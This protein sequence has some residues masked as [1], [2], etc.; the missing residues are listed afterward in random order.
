MRAA[1]RGQQN[2]ADKHKAVVVLVDDHPV[3]R[4]G[5]AELVESDPEL[6]VGGEASN[7]EDAFRIVQ[8]V[9]P[10]LVLVDVSLP[11]V[12]GIELIKR[13]K[14]TEHPPRMLVLSM[15]DESLYADR[16]LQAGAMGYI[17][18]N[19]ATEALLDAIHTVLN[20]TVYISAAIAERALQRRPRGRS[21]VG[22]FSE[23]ELQVFEM[24]GH[25]MTTQQIAKKLGLSPKTIDTYRE[26]LK[27]KLKIS[28]SAELV[29]HAV[30]W[31]L[32][33]R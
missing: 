9:N 3:V 21:S 11:D 20:D 4:R 2:E 18:K 15:Y 19:E 22:T 1:S 30:Q 33:N 5:V 6:E 25:G 17:N 29:R 32:E 12:S 8:E 13:L 27:Q 10:D 16:A 7:A 28:N 23:R 24:I 14:E 31:V 26:H